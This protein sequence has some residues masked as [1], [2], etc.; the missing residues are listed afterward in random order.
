MQRI[1]WRGRLNALLTIT[2]AQS[3]NAGNYS[4]V[5]THSIGSVTSA[6]ATLTVNVG[7]SSTLA[8]SN[9]QSVIIGQSPSYYF[10]FDGNLVDAIGGTATFT[11]NGG[12]I[13]GGD[14]FGNANGAASFPAATS[15]LTLSSPVIINGA[16]S[17][18]SSG[19]LSLL[20]DLTAATGTEYLFSDS[21][22]TSG[23]G[24]PPARRIVLLHL[25]SVA[26]PFNSR[27]ETN[28]LPTQRCP[29]PP[30]AV[31]IILR[32]L[33]ILTAQPTT[34]LIGGSGRWA[35]CSLRAIT[36]PPETA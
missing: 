23:T 5:V 20:F 6:V 19:S 3:T 2:N 24:V 10:K 16:G 4:V 32:V 26:A 34:K 35:A 8:R 13:F 31:G 36:S 18:P 1:P 14:Y 9:Y 15:G 12:A 7:T 21:E 27:P 29:L 11:A 17:T 33:G 22:N 25:I 30:P 28:P